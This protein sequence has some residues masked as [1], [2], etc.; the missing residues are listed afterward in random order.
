MTDY[1][2]QFKK[3]VREGLVAIAQGM[4][5]RFAYSIRLSDDHSRIYFWRHADAIPDSAAGHTLVFFPSRPELGINKNVLTNEE[6]N[7]KCDMCCKKFGYAAGIKLVEYMNS[8][9][10]DPTKK[11]RLVETSDTGQKRIIASSNNSDALVFLLTFTA[12]IPHKRHSLE[13]AE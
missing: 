1:V 8:T 6:V 5:K 3:S 12:A 10:P 13:N 11:W 4:D 7:D 9:D 2:S